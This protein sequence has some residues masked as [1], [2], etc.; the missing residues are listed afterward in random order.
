MAG[1]SRSSMVD[2]GCGELP[3]SVLAKATPVNDRSGDTDSNAT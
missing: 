1:K 2:L 3:V